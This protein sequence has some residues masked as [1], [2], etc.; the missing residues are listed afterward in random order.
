MLNVTATTAVKDLHSGMHGGLAPNPNLILANILSSLH[1]KNEKVLIPGFYDNQEKLSLSEKALL[2]LNLDRQQY[3]NE[4]G[5]FIDINSSLEATCLEPTLEILSIHAGP[6]LKSNQTVIPSSATAS[7]SCRTTYGQEPLEIANLVSD[8]LKQKSSKKAKV[9]VQIYPEFA[10]AVRTSTKSPFAKLLR[11]AC[12]E[13][14]NKPCS[15]ILEGGSSAVASMLKETANVEI[16]FFGLTLL[17]D[18]IHAANESFCLTRFKEGKR[19]L[20]ETLSQL[21]NQLTVSN[22]ISDSSNSVSSYEKSL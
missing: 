6:P 11:Q 20:I 19:I 9:E 12:Q 16:L 13:I 10:R 22:S 3:F 5:A 14:S 18:N 15:F 1:D 21:S 4:T 2:N 17:R 8:F 7:I